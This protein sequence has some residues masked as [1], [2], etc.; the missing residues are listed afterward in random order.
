M[1]KLHYKTAG[2]GGSLNFRCHGIVCTDTALICNRPF[3]YLPHFFP[4][5]NK[6]FKYFT[7]IK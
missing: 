3:A 4:P 1:E 6:Q 2:E 5:E 7:Q